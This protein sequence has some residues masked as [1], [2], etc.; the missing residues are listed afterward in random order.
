MKPSI[1]T[2]SRKATRQECDMAEIMV[3]LVRAGDLVRACACREEL[4]AV[5]ARR[6]ALAQAE[7]DV[8]GA[9][10]TGDDVG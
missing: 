6:S 4:R 7:H 9:Q 8:Y 3:D 1:D 2:P 5:S 10:R